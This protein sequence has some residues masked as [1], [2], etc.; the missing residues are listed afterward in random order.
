MVVSRRLPR[1]TH[2]IHSSLNMRLPALLQKLYSTRKITELM[3]RRLRLLRRQTP[4]VQHHAS[5]HPDAHGHELDWRG[6][7]QGDQRLGVTNYVRHPTTNGLVGQIPGP[8]MT[9][10]FGP[11]F[12]FLKLKKKRLVLETFSLKHL[13]LPPVLCSR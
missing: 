5:P 3:L 11:F 2:Q 12:L 8:D 7:E 4:H 1:Q 13:L 10:S 9:A 6:F